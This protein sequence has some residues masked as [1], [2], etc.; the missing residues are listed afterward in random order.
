MMPTTAAP[1]PTLA[2]FDGD[3]VLFGLGYLAGTMAARLERAR[4][5]ALDG[6]GPLVAL[7][8]RL[9][10][11]GYVSTWTPKPGDYPVPRGEAP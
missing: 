5:L 2:D 10:S 4:L 6:R 11:Y 9:A 7:R 3:P 1:K 8:E